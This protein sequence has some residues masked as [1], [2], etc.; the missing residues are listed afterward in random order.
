MKTIEPFFTT[1]ALVAISVSAMGEE[2]SDQPVHLF[3]LSG[4]SNMAGMNPETGF[5]PEAKK[6]FKDEK[7][8]YIKVAKGGQPIC[9]WVKEWE[10]IAKKKGLDSKRIQRITK[11]EGVQFYQPILDQYKEMLEKYPNPTSVTFCWMQGERDAS[12]GAD[13]A[14]KDALKLLIANLRRDLK[15]PDM[16]FVIGRISDAAPERPSWVAVRKAQREIVN[17]DPRG[18][19][20]DVDDLNNREKDGKVINAVHYTKEGYITLGRRFVRQGHALVTGKKPA[21]DGKPGHE[22]PKEKEKKEKKKEEKKKRAEAAGPR[23]QVSTTED[24]RA[25]IADTDG[26]KIADGHAIAEKPQVSFTSQLKSFPEPIK[27]QDIELPG[28]VAATYFVDTDRCNLSSC[29]FSVVSFVLMSASISSL[30]S[31]EHHTQ[32]PRL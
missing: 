27:L 7:V 16:N 21:E 14:Y 4:Q 13:A 28:R 18:A 30:A 29:F 32:P 22:E 1:L 24:W 6:L 9:R 26:V 20:V 10:D 12:G 19:W 5:M 3:I 2:K 15:R 8:D 17:E 25:F 23:W 31:P 11:G